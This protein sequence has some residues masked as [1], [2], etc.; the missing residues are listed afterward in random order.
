MSAPRKSYKDDFSF[1]ADFHHSRRSTGKFDSARSSE[2]KVSGQGRTRA[3]MWTEVTK[4]LVIKE[5][6][7]RM[8]YDYEET[9]RFFYVMEYLK[10]VSLPTLPQGIPHSWLRLGL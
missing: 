9:D 5:A 2:I 8:G 3:D 10:Y 7:D 6:I 1:E 4:D